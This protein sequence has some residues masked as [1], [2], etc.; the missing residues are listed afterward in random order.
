M[1]GSAY[2]EE[3]TKTNRQ[4]QWPVCNGEQEYCENK[5]VVI[6]LPYNQKSSIDPY[7]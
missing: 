7:G 2:V 4:S 5:I 6:G 3:K 1:T